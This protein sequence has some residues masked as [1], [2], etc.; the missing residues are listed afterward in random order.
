MAGWLALERA[1]VSWFLSADSGRSAV[2]AAAGRKTT[3]RSITVDGQ[4][5]EFSE[6]FTDLHTRVYEEVLAGRGFGI[7]DARP[8][9]ELTSTIRQ[10]PVADAHAERAPSAAGRGDVMADYFGP[11]VVVRR[12]RLRDRRGHEDLALLPRHAAR[13]DRP[14]AA[15]S[16][17]TS[18]SRRDVVDRRQR[19]DPEQR[20]GLHRRDARRRRVLRPVDG[21]HQRRQ[22]AQPR[23]AQ[24]RV[25]AD[26]GRGAAPASA[27]TARSCAATRSAATRSSAPARSSRGTCPTTR[28]SSATRRGSPAGCASAA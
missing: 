15:T 10:A 22:S 28:W 27:P 1:D 4:E 7:D 18:S 2:R 12:R 14:R 20:V 16:A 6:G 19:Q 26:A 23:V 17:R 9:I 13:E 5:I 24:G 25:P 11:S 3:F 8:S 21:V